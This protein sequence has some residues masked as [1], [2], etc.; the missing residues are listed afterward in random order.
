LVFGGGRQFFECGRDH[1]HLQ[2]EAVKK[3]S[4]LPS[5]KLESLP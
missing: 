2:R 3:P 1:G 5:C 4:E